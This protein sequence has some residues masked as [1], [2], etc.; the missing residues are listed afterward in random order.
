MADRGSGKLA[1]VLE[2]VGV[3][4]R[5]DKCCL[6]FNKIVVKAHEV[7]SFFSAGKEHIS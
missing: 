2:N 6:C 5:S 4:G 7:A 3:E 1:A